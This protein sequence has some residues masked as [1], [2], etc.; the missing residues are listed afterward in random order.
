MTVDKGWICS[1]RS[2]NKKCKQF[3]VKKHRKNISFPKIQYQNVPLTRE[4]TLDKGLK[5]FR[6]T[7][8]C[9]FA[10]KSKVCLT[11]SS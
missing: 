6:N 8:L 4:S 2:T 7:L 5:A 11:L 9:I 1:T 3:L 10:L